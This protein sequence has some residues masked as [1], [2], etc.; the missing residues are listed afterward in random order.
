[1]EAIPGQQEAY[2]LKGEEWPSGERKDLLKEMVELLLEMDEDD[3]V[4][5]IKYPR[6]LKESE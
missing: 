1:M 3:L 5:M 2:S 4:A 6:L